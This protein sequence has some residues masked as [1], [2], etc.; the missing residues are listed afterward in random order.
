MIPEEWHKMSIGDGGIGADVCELVRSTSIKNNTSVIDVR[1]SDC[2]WRP[3][4]KHCT[5]CYGIGRMYDIAGK[6]P[7]CGAELNINVPPYTRMHNSPYEC[8]SCNSVI[9]VC[10]TSETDPGLIPTGAVTMTKIEDDV[11]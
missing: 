5:V 8:Q 10:K 7:I 4:G 2:Y 6:C 11:I 9:I 3:W 1:M